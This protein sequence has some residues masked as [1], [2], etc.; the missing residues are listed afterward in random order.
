M[1]VDNF[2]MTVDLILWLM[3]F[4]W[5]CDVLVLC[6][7]LFIKFECLFVICPSLTVWVSSDPPENCHLTVQKMKIFGNFLTLIWQLSGGS[8]DT[9]TVC[10]TDVVHLVNDI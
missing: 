7:K 9:Q 5:W 4:W 6:D 8:D 10:K 3:T 2:G 1:N